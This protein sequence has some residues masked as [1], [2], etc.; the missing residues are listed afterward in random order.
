MRSQNFAAARVADREARER[1]AE[2]RHSHFEALVHESTEVDEDDL[3]EAEMAR[4][5][6]ATGTALRRTWQDGGDVVDLLSVPLVGSVSEAKPPGGKT[7][8]IVG[9]K[10]RRDDE[11]EDDVVV[12]D[13]G[14]ISIS[15]T[16]S[17]HGAE[18]PVAGFAGG[19]TEV[20]ADPLDE[21]V[22]PGATKRR[23]GIENQKVEASAAEIADSQASQALG[24]KASLA[25]A[26]RAAMDDNFG[27][28]LG[29]KFRSK[30]GAAGDVMRPG[31]EQ[32]YAY[33]PLNPRLLGK[34][35]Q[36]KAAAT[37]SKLVLKKSKVAKQGGNRS[38]AKH[39][40][41]ARR[42]RKRHTQ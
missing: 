29:D 27:A 22:R 33:L 11:D 23:R 40:L 16:G 25:R 36:H 32:P 15:A 24:R 30:K 2:G 38:R 31:G 13:S 42:G 28:S 8:R 20:E 5:K 3:E 9:G 7:L 39:G 41:E 35:Q 10:R 21:I 18:A 4:A 26:R 6:H 34:K 12:N 14:K 37:M 1:S 17:V 19:S